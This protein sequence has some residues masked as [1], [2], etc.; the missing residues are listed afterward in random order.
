MYFS[1]FEIYVNAEK[2]ISNISIIILI[3][4]YVKV[5]ISFDF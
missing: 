1:I 3:G 4:L 5:D 2:Y